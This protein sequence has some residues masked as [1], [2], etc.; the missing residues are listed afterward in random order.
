MCI[1]PPLLGHPLPAHTS[2]HGR[3]VPQSTQLRV[4]T[5]R[6]ARVLDVYCHVLAGLRT[7]APG[8]S[9]RA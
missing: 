7:V 9:D 2:S 1:A 4:A 6:G 3:P 5:R 8:H